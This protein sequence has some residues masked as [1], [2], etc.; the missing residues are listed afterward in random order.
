M[1]IPNGFADVAYGMTLA[2]D[3]EPMF[4]TMG[5]EW[6]SGPPAIE[7]L[8]GHYGRFVTLVRARY[9][10]SFTFSECRFTFG[11]STGNIPIVVFP[12][13]P[14]AGSR[15]GVNHMPNNSA[16]L[17]RKAT[18]LGGRKNRGRMFFPSPTEENVGVVGDVLTAERTAWNTML[19]AWL[20]GEA[21]TLGLQP[22]LLHADGVTVPTVVTGLQTQSKIATQRR[23]LRP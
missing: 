13:A 10:S 21:T 23:R 17:I 15:T 14:L 2:G 1:P 11:T 7:V 12:E 5:W 4:V 3:P 16:L 6:V 18:A 22:V 20:T 8:E 9:T 19:T